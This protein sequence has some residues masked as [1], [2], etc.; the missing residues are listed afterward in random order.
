MA[1]ATTK[2]M[3]VLYV[4]KILLQETDE[5]HGLTMGDFI[6]KL[7]AY[8]ISAERKS[9]YMDFDELRAIGMDIAM[10][11][12]NKQFYYYL[13]S[14]DFELAELKLLVDAVQS[15]K[16]ITEKKSA[17]LI[18]K[19]ENLVSRHEAKYLHR[20]VMISGRVK[21]MNE[22]IYY[23]VDALQNAILENRQVTF[24]YYNWNVK[25]EQELRHGGERYKISPWGLVWDDEYYYLL[26]YDAKSGIIKS[27]RVD[28]M[29]RIFRTSDKREGE[30][31]FKE[32][33]MARYTKSVFGMFGGEMTEVTLEAKN[34]MA[35]ILVDR[36]GRDIIM[37]PKDENSFTCTVR[38]A[39]SGQFYGWLVALGEDIRIIAPE[40]AVDGMRT[41]AQRLT[42]QYKP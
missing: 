7:S 29:M 15:A 17:E 32:L 9:I 2:K 35:G 28:K 8:G 13:V 14:R 30:D 20:Q 31:A 22:S 23:N 10:Q 4:A 16:F 21:T 12:K 19:L 5:N 40:I 42:E 33:D 3:K 25:K 34:H 37:I 41:V 1:S 6:D 18:K 27:F 36:F 39:L 11:K 26:G 38:V 24:Q